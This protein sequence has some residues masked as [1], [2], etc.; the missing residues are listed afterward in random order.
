[1]HLDVCFL[2]TIC[3]DVD[4]VTPFVLYSGENYNSISTIL[5]KIIEAYS[6][7][8]STC[9]QWMGHSNSSHYRQMSVSCRYRFGDCLPANYQRTASTLDKKSYCHI[10][11]KLEAPTLKIYFTGYNVA[12]P[13][14]GA[15][16]PKYLFWAPFQ[17]KVDVSDIVM[18]HNIK[19]NKNKTAMRPSHIYN[20]N[21]WLEIRHLQTENAHNQIRKLCS[22]LQLPVT[23]TYVH[24]NGPCAGL[25]QCTF[26]WLFSNDIAHKEIVFS[27]LVIRHLIMI[28]CISYE[29]TFTISLPKLINIAP[30]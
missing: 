22:F 12:P 28:T 9:Y 3:G 18:K 23:E 1:M 13:T 14:I 16:I 6:L 4:G 25:K 2:K 17:Y 19:Y 5:C 20:G 15:I 30:L 24:S 29:I 8:I 10:S 26:Q 7:C 11:Q 27:G 21:P